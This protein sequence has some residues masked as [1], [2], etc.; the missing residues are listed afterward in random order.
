MIL[1]KLLSDYCIEENHEE[2]QLI[3]KICNW[4][5]IYQLLYD[6]ILFLFKN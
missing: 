1:I 4:S 2:N 3:E 6:Y 5:D